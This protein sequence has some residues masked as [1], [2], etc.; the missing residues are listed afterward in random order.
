MSFWDCVKDAIDEGSADRERGERAQRMWEDLRDRYERQGHSRNNAE[1]MAAEDVKEAFRREA[2]ETR[3]VFQAKMANNRKL[4]QGVSS[5]P[6]LAKHQTRTVED[7]DYK[8]RGLVRRFNGRL[9]SFLRDHHRDLLG[10]VTKPAQMR[11]LLAELHGESTGDAA[12]AAL[13]KGVGE[14]LEDMRLMFNE[15]GGIIGKLDNYGIPHSHSRRAVTKAGFDRWFSDIHQGI[16]WTRIEDHL[17]GRPFQAEGGPAPDLKTQ[18]RFLREIY[19]NIAYGRESREAVYGRPKGSALYRRRAESRVLHFKTS[20]DWIAYNKAYGTGDPFKS[21]MGHVHKMSRDIVAMREFGPNPGLGVEY[22]QQLAMKRARDEGL[23]PQKV[24]GNGNH[25]RRMFAVESGGGM[26]ETLFQ[27][28]VSTFM[29]SAR[30]VMTSAFLDRAIISSVSDLNTMRLAAQAVG[31]SPTN[32]MRRH[33]EIMANELSG[34]EAL[35]AHWVADT[36]ADPGI[37]LA[38]FQSEVP[39]SEIAERLSSASMR[40]QGLSGWTDSARMAFQ[41]EMGG[42]MAGQAGKKL[43][44]ID[45]PI[46]KFLRDSG[47]TEGEWGALTAPEAM[48]TAGN[49]ATFV[50]P[51]Y[52]RE[53]TDLP[54][55]RADEIFFKVQGMIEE[56][57]EFAVPTQSLLARGMLDPG[58]TDLPPGTLPYEIWKSGLMFKSFAMTFT[59]NQFR[60]T[61]AQPTLSGKIGYAMNL[62]AGATVMGGIALQLSEIIK[63]NDPM[64]MTSPAFWGKAT[65][66]GGGLG[67]IGD[68]VST[69]QASWGGGFPAYVAGPVPQTI[70][71]VWNLTIKNAWEFATGQDTNFAKELTDI[72]R[73]YTPMGQ[74]PA[75]GPA[76]DRLLWDQLQML[77]DP[78]SA[79]KIKKRAQARENRDGNSSWWMPGSPTPDRA[80]DISGILGG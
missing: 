36:L 41:W 43:A 74:T 44:D 57:T 66:K 17:T 46:G 32:V 28:Y 10:N 29:S 55:D 58:S 19:D 63:G 14:A 45:H 27:D 18:E 16:E 33:V 48:F 2:G 5:A 37:A 38:R 23:D 76:M 39:P 1:A 35:R 47:L 11:N 49:G 68:I 60:R 30:H 71:D 59:V 62:A 7:L 8:A 52:W 54:R 31:A 4:Q 67:I 51:L 6:D 73:R 21:L 61:M 40:I 72:G 24:E 9:A 34:G 25:A 20:D 78:E 22:Q 3:H 69:G 56:Q 26:P 80:P 42:V 79:A 50:D 75:I 77:L 64:D 65:L 70:G 53:A 13:A 15:A 12:A